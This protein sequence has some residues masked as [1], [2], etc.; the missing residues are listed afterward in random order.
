MLET[1]GFKVEHSKLGVMPVGVSC[2]SRGAS[3]EEYEEFSIMNMEFGTYGPSGGA[4]KIRQNNN[5]II[6]PRTF[7]FI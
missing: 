4:H 2:R 3:L 1:H 5:D 6:E 7:S